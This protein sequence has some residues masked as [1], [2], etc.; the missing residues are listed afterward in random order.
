[1]CWLFHFLAYFPLNAIYNATFATCF[2]HMIRYI[3]MRISKDSKPTK[4]TQLVML[5]STIQTNPH[6]LAKASREQCQTLF[7]HFPAQPYT[8]IFIPH[9]SYM[10]RAYKL[11]KHTPYSNPRCNSAICY[12]SRTRIRSQKTATKHTKPNFSSLISLSYNNLNIYLTNKQ[13]KLQ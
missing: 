2:Q 6:K 1:M 8:L 5:V 12:M 10:H 7:I 11:P 3:Y 13:M 9:I 4:T